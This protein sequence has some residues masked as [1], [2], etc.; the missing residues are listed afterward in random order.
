[1]NKVARKDGNTC[2]KLSIE[3]IQNM[4]FQKVLVYKNFN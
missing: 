3:D 2:L 1:V 4:G